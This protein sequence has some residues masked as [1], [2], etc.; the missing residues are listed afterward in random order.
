MWSS[1][2]EGFFF[3][4]VEDWLFSGNSKGLENAFGSVIYTKNICE[5]RKPCPP[6]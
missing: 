5:E 6:G 4:S 3:V 1:E 2:K